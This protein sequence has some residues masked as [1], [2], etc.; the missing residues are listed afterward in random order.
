MANIS[1]A[2]VKYDILDTLVALE[3]NKIPVKLSDKHF[4]ITF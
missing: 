1:S 3:G 2:L 4:S